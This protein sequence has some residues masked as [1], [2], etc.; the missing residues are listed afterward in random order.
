MS[1]E[2]SRNHDK[3]RVK[4]S[5]CRQNDV[6]I[7]CTERRRPSAWTQGYI[8]NVTDTR[9][10]CCS[11]TRVRGVLM[12]GGIKQRRFPFEH[13]LG[14]VT[15][16]HVKIDY[17]HFLDPMPNLCVSGSY[18]HVVKKAKTHS[19]IPFSM[20]SGRSE[21][22]KGLSLVDGSATLFG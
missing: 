13:M 14:T 16:V 22:T 5:K 18:S 1:V 11:S 3:V 9:F 8:E 21:C 15:M 7:R 17:C 2:T 10:G 20:V 19:L 12:A 4:Y 6:S